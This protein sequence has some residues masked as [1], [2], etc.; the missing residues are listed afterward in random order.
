MFLSEPLITRLERRPAFIMSRRINKPDGSFDGI[1]SAT[2]DLDAFQ[3][4]YQALQLGEGS[5]MNLLRDDGTLIVRQPPIT[6]AVGR[7]FPDLIA[8]LAQPQQNQTE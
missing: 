5:A 8:P 7:R 2:V 4:V 3:Q 6:Q 1:V